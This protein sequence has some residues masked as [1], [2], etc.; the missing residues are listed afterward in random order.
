MVCGRTANRVRPVWAATRIDPLTVTKKTQ[1][2]S[3]T[4][5]EFP[6]SVLLVPHLPNICAELAG[7]SWWRRHA[8]FPVMSA[9][10]SRQSDRPVRKLP[11]WA[12]ANRLIAWAGCP[13]T[14]LG[15]S[16]IPAALPRELLPGGRWRRR[17]CLPW[18]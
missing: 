3:Q 7:R 15:D 17:R 16:A 4:V 14:G 13:A 11:I 8:D 6:V 5:S 10:F 2:L 9:M 18:R 1:Q 12:K